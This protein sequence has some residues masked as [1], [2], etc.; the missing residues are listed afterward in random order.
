VT[1]REGALASLPLGEAV[2]RRSLKSN[3]LLTRVASEALFFGTVLKATRV[4]VISTRL[5]QLAER[6]GSQMGTGV[7]SRE[8]GLMSGSMQ[9]S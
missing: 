3:P 8:I 7:S 5:V 1:D 6:L 2:S 4:C 9:V